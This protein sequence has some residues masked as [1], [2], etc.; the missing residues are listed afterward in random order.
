LSSRL[1]RRGGR[2]F[3]IPWG[4]Q[5]GIR[6]LRRRL[7]ERRVELFQRQL[8]VADALRLAAEVGRAYLG[9]D[10]LEPLVGAAS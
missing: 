10:R 4:L 5:G 1:K 6:L 7:G 8:I 9:Q 2:S 3:G